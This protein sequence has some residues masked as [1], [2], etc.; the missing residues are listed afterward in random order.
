MRE[1]RTS[2]S[3]RGE[4]GASFGTVFPSPLLYSAEG[5]NESRFPKCRI[6]PPKKR[7]PS[8]A[9]LPQDDIKRLSARAPT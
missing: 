9:T 1:I 5:A 2:G 6:L 3:M 4:W 7:D 8:V